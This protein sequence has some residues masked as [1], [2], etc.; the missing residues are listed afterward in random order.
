MHR[1]L[2]FHH[3]GSAQAV[4]EVKKRKQSIE[5]LCVMRWDDG[6]ST[7]EVGGKGAFNMVNTMTASLA[8]VQKLDSL[9]DRLRDWSKGQFWK[10]CRK[11]FRDCGQLNI[12]IR[13]GF[14]AWHDFRFNSLSHQFSN[15][16]F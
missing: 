14:R 11:N 12:G 10:T 8:A 4:A 2:A 5:A 7:R 15:L 16:L 6:T 3:S 9:W 1:N 13:S